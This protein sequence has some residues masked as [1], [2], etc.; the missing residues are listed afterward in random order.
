MS[1]LRFSAFV[2]FMCL[3]VLGT[4]QE[5]PK[6]STTIEVIGVTPIDG[7]GL[8]RA[9]FPTNAQRVTVGEGAD[10]AESLV[11]GAAAMEVND[12]QGAPLQSDLQFRGFAVSPLLGAP[13]GL[14]LFQ[15]GVRLNEPFGDTIGWTTIPSSAI[16][17]IDV[18][19]GAN[20]V[21]GLNA[22]GGALAIRTRS[23]AQSSSASVRAGSLGRF[24]GEFSTGGER[25][26]A[27]ASHLHDDGWRDFS[28]SDVTQ[29]FASR[30]W[31]SADL[32]LTL[33]R[34]T[35]TGNGPA[36]EELIAADRGAVF[37]HPDET[38][39]EMAMLSTRQQRALWRSTFAEAA[40]YVRHTRTQTF[41]GD[42]SPYEPC[43]DAEAAGLLCLEEEIV[44]DLT[45][46]PVIIPA[47]A[48]LNATNNRTGL[49]QTAFGAT[50]QLDRSNR[51]AQ[52]VNR[53]MAGGSLDG[54][55]AHF[56]SSTELADLTAER[57]TTGSGIIAADSLVDLTTRSTTLSV[58]AADIFAATPRLTVTTTARL[59]HVRMRLDDR[60]DTALDGSHS[61]TQ[62]HPSIGGAYEITPRMSAF[63]NFGV[64]GRTPTPVELSCAD[65]EDP[66]RLPNAFVSDPPLRA[67][68]GRTIEAGLR[69]AAGRA[70]WSA[71]AHRSVS[72]DDLLFISSG[73]LRGEGH[74]ANVGTTRRQGVELAA[75]GRMGAKVAWSAGYAFLD[76]TFITPFVVAAPNH[77][78]ATD[79]EIAVEAGDRLPLVPRHL[80]K[81]SATIDLTQRFRVGASGR[82]VAEQFFRGD[83]ANLAEPLPSYAVIDMRLD[84]RVGTSATIAFEVRNVFDAEHATFGVFGD[85]E[86]VLGEELEDSSRFITPAAPRTIA[87][88]VKMRF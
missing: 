31:S 39:T 1:D 43:H 10:V 72:K 48:D 11:R 22:L 32:R 15:D 4:A 76:A 24:D 7:I 20:P 54:G 49:R 53:V 85:A 65:P 19:P 77:P 68:T 70:T 37:T 71:A 59:N 28:P 8:D 25:W 23:G 56:R 60:I 50:V 26:F 36:P 46:S 55:V 63:A 13:E 44:R 82:T 69:G 18:I 79:G 17:S 35:L 29:L 87:I 61:F 6:Q 57:G 5:P 12:V 78:E 42:D 81:V 86:D 58:F 51:I 47:G 3:P 73:P 33:A 80:A 2:I 16:E 41:N 38:R 34:S 64:T 27:S 30:K 88:G 52:R 40:A 66:C 84:V 21:F 74:F 14:A 9:K 75:D 67:V 45:G 62:L 83:E